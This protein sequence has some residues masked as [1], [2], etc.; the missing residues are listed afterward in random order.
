MIVYS[1][2]KAGG[3]HGATVGG[4]P[5]ANWQSGRAGPSWGCAA[6]RLLGSSTAVALDGVVAR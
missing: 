5:L 1:L 6:G 4:W 3:A 2:F